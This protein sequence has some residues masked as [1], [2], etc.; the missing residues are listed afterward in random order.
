[1]GTIYVHG[2]GPQDAPEIVRARLD[3]MLYGATTDSTRL[4]Y[5]A[6]VLHPGPAR[7]V[8]AEFRLDRAARLVRADG[9]RAAAVEHPAVAALP[10]SSAGGTARASDLA[11]GG[12]ASSLELLAA[13]LHRYHVMLPHARPGWVERTAFRLI[14]ASLLHDVG[15]Y[16]YGDRADEMREPLR[17]I[18]RDVHQPTLLIAH[19]LGSIIAYDVLREREFA[20]AEVA[21]WLTLGSPL[22]VDEVRWLLTTRPAGRRRFRPR[23]LAG[24][25]L[26]IRT[27]QSPSTRPCATSTSREAGSRST[28]SPST[29]GRTTRSRRTWRPTA[30]GRSHA[31]R[32]RPPSGVAASRAADGLWAIISTCAIDPRSA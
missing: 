10:G 3:R 24:P 19:S 29:A 14:S 21:H 13:R 25:I 9:D 17:R 5:H 18:L 31:R 20:G 16:F 4:A 22:A 30:Y 27:I 11:T 1:M 6:D 23:S 32:L 28:G 26:P 7:G 2:A 12:L 8:L 15:A